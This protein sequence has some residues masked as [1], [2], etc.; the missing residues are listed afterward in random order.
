LAVDAVDR[1]PV[2]RFA[3]D[4]EI[5]GR[6]V[7]CDA[8]S[9][10]GGRTWRRLGE[11]PVERA[12]PLGGARAAVP[13]LRAGRI[14][15]GDAI[16]PAGPG[17][18]PGVRVG[19]VQSAVEW[20][21]RAWEP[22]GLPLAQPAGGPPAPGTTV[23]VGY[24]ADG[25]AHVVRGDRVWTSSGEALLPGT[26]EAWAIAGDGTFYAAL[27]PDGRRARAM[28]AANLASGWQALPVPGDLRGLAADGHRVWIAAGMLGRGHH[29][30]WAW[31]RW[32]EGVRI[33][34]VTGRGTTVVAWGERSRGAGRGVLVVSRD[35]GATLELRGL[36][37]MRPTWAAV[38]P[39]RPED[40]LILGAD[41]AMARARI[42]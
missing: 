14:L 9:A 20:R 3:F 8:E 35:G 38:D 39:F 7:T 16:L 15:C 11:A 27:A 2:G 34:G 41:G 30:Q 5:D 25:V 4:P 40:V 10:D 37:G 42:D 12:I 18:A 22:A 26:A 1:P 13:V 29:D 36:D 23:A 28:W 24:T 33:D 21:G 6:V 19:D 17:S 31:T 32:P